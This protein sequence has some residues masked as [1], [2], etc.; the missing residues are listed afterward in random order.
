MA[1]QSEPSDMDPDKIPNIDVSRDLKHAS[2]ELVKRLLRAMEKY[3]QQFPD[4]QI[5]VTATY[6]SPEAQKK[7]WLVGRNGNKGSILTNCDGFIKKSRHNE[8]P[9][10]AVDL[11][12]CIGGK[13]FY[14]ETLMYP[15]GN[16]AKAEGLEWGGFWTKFSD[17][18]HYQLP[19]NLI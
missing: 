7:L 18:P 1:R 2:P 9:S 5:I 4:R 3:K 17:P 6:R 15:L 19:R 14:D 8:Y 13:V 12:I 11:A 10:T 16:M